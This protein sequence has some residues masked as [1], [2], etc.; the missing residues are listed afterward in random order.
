MGFFISAE[1]GYYEGDQQSPGD[2]EVVQRP[3]WTHEFIRGQWVQVVE[4]AAEKAS[5]EAEAA[6]IEQEAVAIDGN[7]AIKIFLSL[8]PA[9]RDA[10][11]LANPGQWLSLSTRAVAY[12][13]RKDLS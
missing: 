13:L 8:S 1:H 6:V 11:A 5:L 2:L 10:W 9:A 3:D 4:K 7:T 12:L